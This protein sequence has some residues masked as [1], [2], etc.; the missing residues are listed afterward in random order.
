MFKMCDDRAMSSTLAA[1]DYPATLI[2]ER[3]LENT[4]LT[5]S[6]QFHFPILMLRRMF[7][8]DVSGMENPCKL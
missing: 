1:Q 8:I 6:Q 7:V 3:R 5:L 4:A 2:K